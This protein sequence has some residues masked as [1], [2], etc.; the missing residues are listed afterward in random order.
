MNES[1]KVRGGYNYNE[2]PVPTA[3]FEPSIPIS[4]RHGVYTGLG[5]YCE[6]KWIDLAYGAIFYEGRHINNT[7]GDSVGGPIDGDYA[8]LNHVWAINFNCRF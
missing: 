6:K 5:Y 7:V 3:T 8:L 4:N 1:I 2:T